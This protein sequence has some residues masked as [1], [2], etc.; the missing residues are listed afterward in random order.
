MKIL[1]VSPYGGVPGGMTRWT[2]HI[3]R[4]YNQRGLQDCELDL[5]PMG[6]NQFVNINSPILYRLWTAFK[7]YRL[8]LKKYKWQLH[9]KRYDVVHLASSASLSLSKDLYIIRQ[10]KRKGTKSIVHFHFGRIPELSQAR[11]WEW[12]LLVK[13]VKAA[14]QVVVMDKAS[15]DTL[16][17]NGFENISLLPNPVAPSVVE[18]AAENAN[19]QRVPRSLLF[20]GHVVKTKGVFELL[21][22]CSK[23]ENINLQLVGHITSDMQSQ[24]SG[25]YKD[26]SWLTIC[27]EKPYDDVVKEMCKCDVFVLPTYTEGFPNV[28][29]ESMACGCAIVTTPVGAIPEM[30]ADENGKYYGVMVEPRNVEQLKAGIEKMLSDADFKNECRANVQ[31]RV[32]ERYNIDSVWRQMVDIWR[33]VLSNKNSRFKA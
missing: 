30:L 13:V 8:I 32:I 28:I 14:D 26:A 7:D 4:Y 1:L 9:Q 22:A 23:I 17:A 2:E 15:Y 19:I 25:Q 12:K 21:E 3:L 33:L 18:I 27:G 24:I 10:A 29:L 5:V 31:Q 11:N 16:I 6:R 20:V